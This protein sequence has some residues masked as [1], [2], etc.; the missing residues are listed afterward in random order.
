MKFP[1]GISDFRSI[2]LEDY[3]YCDRTDKIPLL[4][5]A[6]YQLFIRPRR[7]GKSL[8][9]SM[10]D[11]YYDILRKDE[12]EKLFGGCAIGDKPT[13]LRNSYFILRFDFS[14]VDPTGT[15]AEVRQSFCSHINNCIIRFKLH[16]EEFDL[17]GI[18]VH[19]HDALSSMQSLLNVVSKKEYPV[20]LLIDEYDNFAN[21]V[22]MGVRTEE[23]RYTVLVHEEGSLK[24]LFKV[25]KS[26][27]ASSAIDRMFITGVSP[28]VMSDITSG[29]NI[30]EN[31]YLEAEFNDL[32]GFLFEELETVVAQI[33]SDCDA[34]QGKV[35]EALGLLK[36]YYNGYNFSFAL[37]ETPR[38]PAKIPMQVYNP[39][40]SLYFLKQFQKTCSFPRNMLD[41][42]LAVDSAKLEFVAN[43]PKGQKL[44]LDLMEKDREV[45]ISEMA[46]R[47]GIQEMLSDNSRDNAFLASFLYYSG[48]LTL[49]GETDDLEVVLRVPNLVMKKLYIER[50]QPLCDFVE[51]KY[52]KVFDNRD[53]ITANEL[54]VKTAFLTLLYNDLIYLMDSETEN[55]RRYAD[56]TM[57]IRP[58]K[59][60]G[61]VFDILIEFK[62]VSL[63]A[64]GLSGVEAK[65]L[66]V[67]DLYQLPDMVEQLENGV[68]Q[69]K[70]YG[71]QLEQKYSNLRLKKFVVVALGFD[72][73]CFE[74]VG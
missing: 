7:F 61:A 29:F 33:A 18:D 41:S 43:L 37:P 68:K 62:F 50:I 55:D 46:D 12:F 26:A 59:R 30:A 57:I 35:V 28:V 67:A 4:E 48:V 19:E 21:A 25:L 17:V 52:F 47:F 24:T 72:R 5:Q 34:G 73:L 49:Q 65:K 45:V 42:N 6:K 71:H 20:Y 13:S 10:L 51:Q 53:Y 39:T 1:Y 58:D 38:S 22:M 23:A 74:A 64:V 31:I 69:V 40:L 70:E 60:H 16:Y 9:L 3:F 54:T 63:S 36:T 44:L 56:L 2:I 27:T 8:L 15:V 66:F 11:N 14:C 32:C